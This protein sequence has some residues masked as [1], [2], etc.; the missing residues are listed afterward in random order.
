MISLNRKADCSGCG[1]CVQ[2]CPKSCIVL[3]T[4]EEG[5]LYP[6]VD[7]NSCVNCG[8]CS[9]VCGI[10][11][12]YLEQIPKYVYGAQIK[13]DVI[14]DKSSSGGVFSSMAINVLKKGGIVF[15]ARFDKD[16]NVIIDSVDNVDDLEQLRGSK[17]VQA[18]VGNSY[19]HAERLLKAGRLILF[20][21]TP[22]IISGLLHYLRKP[23]ENLLTCDFVCHGVPSPLVWN[24]Y[25]SQLQS[26]CGMLCGQPKFR[27]KKKGWQ[28]FSFS[29]HVEYDKEEMTVYS[30]HQDNIYMKAFLSDLILRPSCY[31]CKFKKGKSHSDITLADF[32][33]IDKLYPSKFDDRGTGLVMVNSDKGLGI[34]K[35]LDCHKWLV[36][37][38]K[39]MQYNSAFF[40]SPEMHP[41]RSIFFEQLNICSENVEKLID[42]YVYI[43]LYQR[44]KDYVKS[45]IR[46][47]KTAKFIRG[48]PS[49]NL[50]REAN[51]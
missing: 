33:G 47:R 23:Y 37:F 10:L 14:L 16:F 42:K 30:D 11:S 15:G 13:D 6:S 9:K 12:P 39:V 31:D 25:I 18:F 5:F 46:K 40:K 26:K 28:R 43:N 3:Q 22:C 27:N 8:Q 48:R 38:P 1:A 32:W 2:K 50:I 4:D 35:E 45:Y 20:S 34:I 51:N 21:G 24:L 7:E 36:D 29:Y 44:I 17:Y 19:V 49:E 41:N